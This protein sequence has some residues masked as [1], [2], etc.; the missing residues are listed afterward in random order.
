MGKER[1]R[2]GDQITKDLREGA[3]I[4]QAAHSILSSQG[5][6]FAC[7]RMAGWWKRKKETN[8]KQWLKKDSR[9]GQW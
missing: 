2:G 4:P 9:A 7:D 1:W 3:Q 6:G 8:K 5:Q